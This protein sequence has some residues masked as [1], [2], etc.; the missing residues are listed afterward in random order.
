M[1]S[2]HWSDKDLR[3]AV[4]QSR[5]IRQVLGKLGL[6]QA[7][8]NY[9][10]IQRRIKELRLSCRHMTGR[11]WNRGLFIPKPAAPLEKILRRGSEYQSY[12]LKQRLFS[13][14]IKALR[15]ELCGWARRSLDGR[16]PL[17]LDHINGDRKDNRL[18]NLRILCPN[19]NSLKSTHRGLNKKRHT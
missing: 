16:I 9:V 2:K 19:C 1:R 6:V 13:S 18:V 4:R 11:G 8:G 5:S 17:E 12:K 3:I 10:Q 15:C 14:K 7:G